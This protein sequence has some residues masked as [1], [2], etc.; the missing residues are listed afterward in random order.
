MTRPIPDLPDWIHEGAK[1]AE[2]DTSPNNNSAELATVETIT[3]VHVV[4]DNGHKYL[5]RTLHKAGEQRGSWSGH[6]ELRPADDPS[7]RNVIAAKAFNSLA[8]RVDR[9]RVAN[10]A[11][12][13]EVLTLLDAVERMVAQV[14]GLIAP[15]SDDDMA[16]AARVA[17]KEQ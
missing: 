1:V 14:R 11:S 10:S 12:A 15:Q 7:V 2:Y 17:D 4:L 3:K 5:R 9:M 6:T 8:Y 16:R 13:E